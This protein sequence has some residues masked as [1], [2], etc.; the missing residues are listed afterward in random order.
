[1]RHWWGRRGRLAPSD[2]PPGP[3]RDLV[4]APPAPEETPVA[5]VD[6]LSVDFET[7]GLDPRRDHILAIGWVPLAAGE[8]RLGAAREVAVRPPEGTDVG[9]SATVHGLTDDSLEHASAVADVLPALLEALQGRVLLAH[10]APL[11][12]GFLQR[13][14][15]EAFD[16]PLPLTAVD[17]L[18]LQQ[19]LVGGPHGHAPPGS[20]RLDAARRQFGLPRYGAHSA[21]TDAIATAELLLAQTAELRHRRGRE[22]TLADLS[23]HHSR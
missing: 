3:V 23:P 7:T 10:H 2:V 18:A 17:T 19:R 5:E 13:A 21:I 11:E 14:V 1:M 8:V 9:H 16:C 22:P 12:V 6:F 20:L 15:R 4:A